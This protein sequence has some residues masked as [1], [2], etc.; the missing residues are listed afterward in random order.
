MQPFRAESM[1]EAIGL[2]GWAGQETSPQ[3]GCDDNEGLKRNDFRLV[4]PLNQHQ[5]PRKKLPTKL[6]IDF[7]LF[8]AQA[9]IAQVLIQERGSGSCTQR[10]SNPQLPWA[11]CMRPSGCWPGRSSEY[12]RSRTERQPFMSL[13][14]ANSLRTCS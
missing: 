9:I 10:Y 8:L 3:Q 1:G 5:R 14:V 12:Q 7:P 13:A 6:A 11:V 2:K 4:F